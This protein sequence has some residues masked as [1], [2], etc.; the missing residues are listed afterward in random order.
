MKQNWLPIKVQVVELPT[1]NF[2]GL[3]G[4]G[5][6]AGFRTNVQYSHYN[7]FKRGWIFDS[8]YDWEQKQRTGTLSLSTPQNANHYQWSVVGKTEL[9]RTVDPNTNTAQIG[10]HYSRKLEHA[11]ISY[12]LI[13]STANWVICAAMRRFLGCLGQKI[14]WMIPL[15]HAKVMPLKHQSVVH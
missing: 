15:F 3:V 4:Y 1:Q 13:I 14:K 9:D 10:L 8:R 5:T 2:N 11:S 6:D 7:V 12:D